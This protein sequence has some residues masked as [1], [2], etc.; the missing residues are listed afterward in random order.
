MACS[1][2]MRVWVGLP[3]ERVPRPIH[4]GR[5][6]ALVIYQRPPSIRPQR[7]ASYSSRP[8][9]LTA[10]RWSRRRRLPGGRREP[11]PSP[12]RTILSS[13]PAPGARWLE[14]TSVLMRLDLSSGR[15]GRRL[16]VER[17]SAAGAASPGLQLS[18]L[19]PLRTESLP[20]SVAVNAGSRDCH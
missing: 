19:T 4:G 5:R 6:Q 10:F 9:P 12:W 8:E 2:I 11:G 18:G 1:S 14:L 20:L 15:P 13:L 16:V 3:P 7:E 17:P